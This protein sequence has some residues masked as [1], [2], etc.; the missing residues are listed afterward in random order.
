MAFV[1]W[2]ALRD[3]IK[4]KIAD[5]IAGAPITG[6]YMIAGRRM[7][8]RSIDDLK[9]LLLL[10]YDMEALEAAG[11]RSNCVSYGRHRRFG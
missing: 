5:Y 6:E 3:D 2:S 11:E 7:V 10:T 1:S 9:R 8:Y 4:D